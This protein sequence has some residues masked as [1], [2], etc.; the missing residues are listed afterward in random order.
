M[1]C[2]VIFREKSR[3]VKKVLYRQ[4]KTE[5]RTYIIAVKKFNPFILI[6]QVFI[7]GTLYTL[8]LCKCEKS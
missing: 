4:R 2:T 6:M 8:N 5:Q 7:L 1:L 3:I